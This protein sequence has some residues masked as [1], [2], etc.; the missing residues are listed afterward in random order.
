[1]GFKKKNNDKKFPDSLKRTRVKLKICGMKYPKNI[2]SV[3]KLQADYLGFIFYDKSPR[4]FEGDIPEISKDIKRTGVFVDA[5][6]E[7]VLEKVK[8]YNLQAVQ[9]HGQESPDYCNELS[10]NLSFLHPP[11]QEQDE[12]GRQESVEIIKAFSIKNRFDFEVLE[13]YEEVCDYYL[14]DTKG[15]LPGGNGYTFDWSVLKNYPSKK[16]F[17][18]SGGIGSEEVENILSFLQK[19]ES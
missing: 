6:V 4:F 13:P 7:N 1:M 11:C 2:Q 15:K 14:F 3:A 5:P 16:P 17:F 8:E 12:A 10:N 19:K 18:L 9:L